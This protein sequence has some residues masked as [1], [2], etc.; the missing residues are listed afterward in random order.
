MVNEEGGADPEQFRV[1]GMFDRVDAIGKSILGITTQCAQCH[2]HKY[3]PLTQH[4]YYQMFAALNDFHEA[5]MTVYTPQQNAQRAE[6]KEKVAAIENELQSAHADWSAQMQQWCETAASQRPRWTT[7]T[8]TSVPFDGQKFRILDD[9]SVIG[10]SYAPTYTTVVFPTS[11]TKEQVPTGQ[12]T[13]LRLDALTHAQLPHNGPGR[14]IYGTGALTEFECSYAPVNDPAKKS[15]VKIIR[16]FSDV[17]PDQVPLPAVYRE[18]EPEKDERITGPIDFAIDG[19]SKTAWSTDCG[20]AFRNQNRHAIFIPETPIEVGDGITLEFSLAM[21]HGGWNSDDNQNYL[22]GRYRLSVTDA[23]E[24]ESTAAVPSIV[25]T[26]LQQEASDWKDEQKRLVFAYWRT[27]KSEFAEANAAIAELWKSHPE[28]ASQLAVQ[29]LEEPRETFVML[30]G[31]FL[32]AGDRVKPAT[33]AFLNSMPSDNE[34]NRL[35]FARWLV[36]RDSPTAARVVVNRIWQ[37]YFGQGIVTTPEDFGYQSPA[38]AHPEVLDWLAVE[39]M[40]NDWSLKHIH[41]LIVNSAVYQQSS[42]TTDSLLEKDP[43]NTLL[44][45]G[46]RFRVDAEVVRDIAL[47]ASGLL[48]DSLGGPSV[49]PPA[50]SFLFEPPASYGPKIWAYRPDDSQYRRSLYVHTYR[51]VQHPP[52][53]VFDAPKGDAACVRRERSNTPLQALVLLNEPQFMECARALATRT[54]REGGAEDESKL[55]YAHR[56]C[57]SRTPTTDEIEVLQKLLDQQRERISNGEIDLQA[58]V[59]VPTQVCNQLT[60]LTADEVA[61]W[62]VVA[63][64][65]LNLD[66][67]ITK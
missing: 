65:L 10:E 66:E 24:V 28:P 61:P 43:S 14:S 34:P 41:R 64:A 6:L 49:Y 7:V 30:R 51:S 58:I 25:E 44:A 3:D 22:L 42:H 15:K 45:R 36:A 31:D 26:V 12:I 21:N 5:I 50:P 38:P 59:G 63:R 13:A 11:V 17:N 57:T 37:S 60:G 54:L 27:Q 56:L 18:R 1:E 20:P 32:Q 67:T 2:T 8:P 23:A 39:L 40:E 35:R 62:I 9:G 33:P 55:V 16:A 19:D 47:S 52:L 48:N 29:Q 46:P 53:Q 4:E